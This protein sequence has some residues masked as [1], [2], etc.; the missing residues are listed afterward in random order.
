MDYVLEIMIFYYLKTL[1]T[2][3]CQFLIKKMYFDNL[4]ISL[5]TLLL[6]LVWE[7]TLIYTKKH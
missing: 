2:I 1:L 6:E 5:E 4:I 3:H 7:T